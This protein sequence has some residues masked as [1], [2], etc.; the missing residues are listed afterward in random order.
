MMRAL[1]C[2]AAVLAAPQLARADAYETSVHVEWSGGLVNLGDPTAGGTETAPAL[3]GSARFTWA[4]R[5][6]LAWQVGARGVFTNAIDHERVM[7]DGRERDFSRGAIGLG[8]DG[9]AELRFGVRIIPTLALSVGPQL[10]VYPATALRDSA[11][12]AG[13]G[14]TPAEMAFDLTARLSAGVDVRLSRRWIIGVRAGGGTALGL[15]AGSW[16]SL[17]VIGH[18]SYYWYPRWF[19]LD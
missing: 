15:G 11:S 5:D 10:R 8:L 17:E 9:G 4:T 1:T 2:I 13:A 12:G 3:G 7:I 19:S 6:W 14:Q 18:I 16:Q